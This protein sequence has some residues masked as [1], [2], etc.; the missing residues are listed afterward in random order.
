MFTHPALLRELNLTAELL[1]RSGETQWSRRINQAADG[2]RK[3]GWTAQGI[4]L[5]RDLQRGQ[6]GLN[7][8]NFG[9]EHHR[10]LGGEAGAARANQSLERHRLKLE[11]LM[12]LPTRTAPEGARPKSPD[13]IP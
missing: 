6:G 2:L 12:E 3:M 11:Q 10:Q 9:A 4:E 1:R 13:L 7:Q 8:V 5:I